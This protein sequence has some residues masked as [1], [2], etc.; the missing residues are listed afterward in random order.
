MGKKMNAAG[1]AVGIN[2]NW[3]GKIGPD[4]RDA[5][6]LIHLAQARRSGDHGNVDPDGEALDAVVE[7]LFEAYHI[8]AQDVSEKEVLRNIA[9]RAGIQAAEVDRVLDSDEGADIVDK[10]AEESKKITNAGVP[11]LI[12]Q[13]SHRVDSTPDPMDLM[14]LFVKVREEQTEG[15]PA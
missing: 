14:L 1:R 15:Q 12:I 10:Q 9:L 13:G 5:H 7:G 8:L 6:R 2:F 3:G 4:T 11:M